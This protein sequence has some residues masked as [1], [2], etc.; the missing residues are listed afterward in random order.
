VQ[1]SAPSLFAE[2]I[3][4]NVGGWASSAVSLSSQQ[5]LVFDPV[6]IENLIISSPTAPLSS[7]SLQAVSDVMTS[8]I[9]GLLDDTLNQAIPGFPIPSF[10]LPNTLSA[11]GIPNGT[12]LKVE[13]LDL[14]N[15]D[16][17]LKVRGDFR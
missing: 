15:D 16:T 13:N 6:A 10:E 2:P 5:E 17:H 11:F 1:I 9:Q 8:L 7:R 14:Q 4:L 12:V 3:S